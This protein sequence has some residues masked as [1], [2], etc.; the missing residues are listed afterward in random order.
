MFTTIAANSHYLQKCLLLTLFSV[1]YN[2][3]LKFSVPGVYRV[4]IVLVFCMGKRK[5]SQKILK[6]SES[7]N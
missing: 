2:I 5:I 3:G 1:A 4:L 6:I 7:G